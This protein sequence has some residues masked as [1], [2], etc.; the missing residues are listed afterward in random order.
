MCSQERPLRVLHVVGS[1]RCG[2]IE[3]WLMRLLRLRRP[4]W[5]LDFLVYAPPGQNG[6][7][8]AE[9]LATGSKIIYA[10]VE[11]RMRRIMRAVKLLPESNFL[12]RT[13]KSSNYD[14][15]HVHGEEF[16]G[17]AMKAAINAGVP[18]RVAHCHSA[19]LA[20][21]KSGPEMWIRWLR[22]VTIDRTRLL[23]CGTDFLACSRDA[24]RL[25]VGARWDVDSR[26]QVHYCGIPLSPFELAA[27]NVTRAQLLARY[28]IPTDAIIIGQ[29]GSMGPTPIKNQKFLVDVFATLAARSPR[30]YLFMA[31]DGP[32]RPVL[33]EQ[34]RQL[35]L[36]D[37]VRMPGVIPNVLEL[38]S[39]LFDVHVMPSINEGFGI[40]VIEATAAG[41]GSV[42][43]T[44][45]PQEVSDSFPGRTLRISLTAP[46]ADW[47]D[48]II[49]VLSWRKD[50]MSSIARLRGTLFS[51]EGSADALLQIYGARRLGGSVA[52]IK[53]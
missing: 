17:D 7:Y 11:S 28:K 43:S 18:V 30:Y 32:L 48:K 21:G 53:K 10:P 12:Y 23:Q 33:L 49:E 34:I 39:M 47:A 16:L 13:L 42:L 31:G 20:R 51:V 52:E 3:T 2:G 5:Q 8:E 37:R 26:C 19:V 29:V 50:P 46:I 6:E 4:E 25:L 22:H 45:V 36:A 44:G 9:A 41:L 27:A 38:M 14:V 40:T 35:G 24:G 15:V 1:L